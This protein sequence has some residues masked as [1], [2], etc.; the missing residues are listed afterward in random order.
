MPMTA[1]AMVM[2]MGMSARRASTAPPMK[3]TKT[4]A[5]MGFI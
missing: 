3:M 4:S 2:P 1:S 5:L